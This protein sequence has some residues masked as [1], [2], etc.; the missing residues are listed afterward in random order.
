MKFR[1]KK[2]LLYL[3]VF[4]FGGLFGVLGFI[5]ITNN[6]NNSG[7]QSITAKN[8]SWSIEANPTGDSIFLSSVIAGV[9]SCSINAMNLNNDDQ[10][11][12]F[13]IVDEIN[14]TTVSYDRDGLIKK[15]PLPSQRQ[16]D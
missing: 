16:G 2:L 5:Q 12:S 6:S 10:I 1:I 9:G 8:A 4:G 14:K 11:V 15:E 3:V 13:V 7:F